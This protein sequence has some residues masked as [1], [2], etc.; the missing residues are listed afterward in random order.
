[1]NYLTNM[2]LTKAQKERII[3]HARELFKTNTG[4]WVKDNSIGK[5]AIS[6]SGGMYYK[7]IFTQ[8]IDQEQLPTDTQLKLYVKE[9]LNWDVRT[10]VLL[11][12][13]REDDGIDLALSIVDDNGHFGHREKVIEFKD[14]EVHKV[15]A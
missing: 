8:G 3:H 10:R 14:R 13:S 11:L 2:K 7:N 15:L 6:P 12:R 4:K 5:V 1:M 9:S